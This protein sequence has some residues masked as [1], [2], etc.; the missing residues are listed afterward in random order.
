MKNIDE[1]FADYLEG[2]I[3]EEKLAVFFQENPGSQEEFED[4]KKLFEDLPSLPE[5]EV[6]VEA[7]NTFYSFLEEKTKPKFKID[8]KSIFKYAA[9][10]LVVLGAYFLGNQ[11][12][13]IEKIVT[14]EKPVY[15][16][17][18]VTDTVKIVQEATQPTAVKSD[19]EKIKKEVGEINNVQNKMILAM[20]RQESASSRLQAINYS[21]SLES[22]DTK[23]LDALFETI[24]KDQSVNVKLAALDAVGR[25]DLAPK[26]REELVLSL[27]GQQDPSLQFALINR[28]V[29]LRETTALPV[30]AQLMNNPNTLE[31]IRNQA[32]LGFKTLKKYENI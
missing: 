13:V 17:E 14:I 32:E 24:E 3:S 10:F 22:P 4:L 1:V 18:R 16:T 8:Y 5:I 27:V 29:D 26:Y 2:N 30:F 6:S 15:I 25:F 7:D 21:Y 9:M 11:K 20:L 31:S 28:L 12:Q 23:I 19:I